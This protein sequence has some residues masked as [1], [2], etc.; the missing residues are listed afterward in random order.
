MQDV[1]RA[2]ALSVLLWIFWLAL[3]GNPFWACLA[4]APLLFLT[5]VEIYLLLTYRAQINPAIL[6]IILET[7]PGESRQY[8]QAILLPVA[9]SYGALAGALGGALWVLRRNQP[10][11][12]RRWRIAALIGAPAVIIALHAVYAPLETAANWLQPVPN[13]FRTTIW[14]QEVEDLRFTAPFGVMLQFADGIESERLIAASHRQSDSFRFGAHQV[15]DILA[16][17]VYVLIIGESSR[18]DRWSLN[19][20]ARFTSP[21]LQ[22]HDN[23][24][25]FS[26]VVT[27]APSTRIA[28]PALLTRRSAENM[29]NAPFVERSLVSAFHE[30]GFA[31]Y[32]LSTQAPI[33]AYD[34]AYAAYAQEADRVFY[35]NVTGGWEVTVTDGVM[36]EPLR[37]ILADTSQP[38]QLIVVHTMGSHIDYR[39]RYPSEFDIFKPSLERMDTTRWRDAGYI[40]RLNNAYDNT[41]RYSDYFISEVIDAVEASGRKLATVL[42]V[43]DHGE[44]LYDHGC[45]NW[46]HGKP[47]VAGLRVPMFF[48]YSAAYAQRFQTKISMLQQ[49]RSAPLTLEAVFPLMLDAAGI[50]FPTEDASRSV[51]SSSFAPLPR[52]IAYT[53]TGKLDFNRAHLGKECLLTN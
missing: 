14:P 12:P 16:P 19:G 37:S 9:L 26:D 25:S 30:A 8:L 46:G 32:W 49:H 3:F 7:N 4:V 18:A 11:L 39:E 20:Y 47:T 40:A 43:S 51:M 6:G 41:I 23:L 33:G 24:I 52:R 2:L 28:V 42:Y 17:Q 50:Q 27:V 53:I 22:Q 34:A 31:T 1:L 29:L 48:W 5:P 44:D 45:N 13:A 38:R 10:R 35:Y 36:L 21:R 15:P